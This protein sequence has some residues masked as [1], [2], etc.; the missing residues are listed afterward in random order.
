M[1]RKQSIFKAKTI[2]YIM[3]A[4]AGWAFYSLLNGIIA[5]ILEKLG[6]IDELWQNAIVVGVVII[7]LVGIGYGWHRAF[8]KIIKS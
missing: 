4:M 8:N 1:A 7:I 2:T 3:I 6:I 5:R